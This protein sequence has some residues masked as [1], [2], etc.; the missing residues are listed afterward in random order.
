MLPQIAQHQAAIAALC[1]R[2]GVVRL[3][4]FG[5]A[6]NGG[7]DEARSDLDFVATF[8]RV[9]PTA[10]YADRFLDFAGALESLLG[11]KVDVVSEHALRF[12]RLG[13]AIAP[14]RETVY[15]ECEPVAV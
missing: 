8:T 9:E 14:S 5:S 2:Y 4:L 6:V 1:R 12:S 11:R 10:A 13:P 3:D 7:Y 15:A